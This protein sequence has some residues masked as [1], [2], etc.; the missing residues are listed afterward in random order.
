MDSSLHELWQTAS[1]SP[2]QPTVGKG[3]QFWVGFLLLVAAFGLTGS[4]LLKRSL[5]G[6][7]YFG[8]PA[9]LALAI[10]IV[11]MFCAVGVYV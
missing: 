6:V 3:S 10:G 9:S 2:F 7:T 8:L 5:A 11:Y 4:F 1:G